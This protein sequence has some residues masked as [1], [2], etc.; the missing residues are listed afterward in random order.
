MLIVC[1]FL[2]KQGIP[3]IIGNY[4]R[5]VIE[6]ARTGKSAAAEMPAKKRQ[7]LLWTVGHISNSSLKYLKALPEHLDLQLS[8]GHKILVV[9]G[10][11]A[12][13]DDA[14]YPSFTRQCLEAK[15][16]DIIAALKKTSLPK[17]L[18]KDFAK[19]NKRR[20]YGSTLPRKK[21][22]D[23]LKKVLNDVMNNQKR[24]RPRW[25]QVSPKQVPK[26]R[27]FLIRE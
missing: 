11:P 6:V 8:G 1:R 27:A 23:S 21:Q 4:D 26:L 19:G 20:F 14:I 18:S 9:Y 15:L 5:K 22:P 3:A 25:A 24:G 7:I 17:A 16:G 13:A 12:S 2:Q 10:S